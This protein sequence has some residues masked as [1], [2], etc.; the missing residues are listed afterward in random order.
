MSHEEGP[1][2]LKRPDIDQ[3]PK[4]KKPHIAVR[5]SY[6]WCPDA[7]LNHG[8]VDFQSAALPTAVFASDTFSATIIALV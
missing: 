2:T 7:E 4:T 6:S 3:K 1:V 5:L 8:H